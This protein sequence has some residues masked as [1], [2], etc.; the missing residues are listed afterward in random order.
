MLN[1]DAIYRAA[2]TLA[3]RVL[4]FQDGCIAGETRIFTAC[5]RMFD[6]KLPAKAVTFQVFYAAPINHIGYATISR[7]GELVCRLSEPQD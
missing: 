7:D 1:Y 5:M 3:N 6:A 4:P 2:K